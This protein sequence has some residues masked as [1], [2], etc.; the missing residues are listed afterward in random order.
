VRKRL[1][2]YFDRLWPICRSV[3]GPGFR[4]S[5]KILSEIVPFGRL[6]FASG[7]KVLDWTV[8]PEWSAKE[9]YFIGPNGKRY[10][11][12]SKNNLHLLNFS[13][14]FKGRMRLEELKK[15]LYTLPAQPKAIP[16]LTSYY[17]RRWGFC[18]THEDFLRLPEGE[19]EVRIDTRIHKGFLEIGEAVLP[20]RTRNEIFFS[21]YLCHPSLAN[22]E[23]SGP[24]ALAFLYEK[25]AALPH[26]RFTYRFAVMPETIGAVSYLSRRGG[27]LKKRMSAGYQITCVGDPGMFTYKRSRRGNSLADRMALEILGRLG[28]YKDLK[29]DPS[30]GSDERQY[31]SPGYN[32]PVGSLMRTMYGHYPQYHTSLDNKE[33][34]DFGALQASVEA[35]FAIVKKLESREVLKNTVRYGEPQ[36]GKRGLYPTLG[37]Q[38]SR[39]DKA[40]VMLWVLNL[41][42]GTRT[43]EEIA[44]DSCQPLPKIVSA[45]RDLEKARLIEKSK[46]AT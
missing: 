11:D 35:Y 30:T 9:A 33:F 22:N 1:E 36:L 4:E 8:P 42:D 3:A 37:S 45:V 12:F 23:L 6:R 17:K 43:L 10:A 2:C 46:G 44:E 41:A 40:A 19:Y 16:Y 13:S 5:L 28:R 32:L 21:S 15:H 31:C 18:L 14:P 27:I 7:Q 26:R 39:N 38:K 24:L 20:G 29:F 25:I 34:I